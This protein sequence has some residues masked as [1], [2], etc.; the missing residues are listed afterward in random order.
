MYPQTVNGFTETIDVD[1]TSKV[2]LKAGY[3]SISFT[4]SKTGALSITA[5][6]SDDFDSN[7]G[8]IGRNGQIFTNSNPVRTNV[9]P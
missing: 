4:V 7:I 9:K 3:A 1:P 6:A 5:S 8:A 2:D